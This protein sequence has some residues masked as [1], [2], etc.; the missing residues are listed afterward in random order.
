MIYQSTYRQGHHI[1]KNVLIFS[2]LELPHLLWPSANIYGKR[3][4]IE[5]QLD[6]LTIVILLSELINKY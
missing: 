1:D 5:E 2:I 3:N 6:S 4:N